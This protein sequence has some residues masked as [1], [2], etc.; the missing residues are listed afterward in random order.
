MPLSSMRNG[1]SFVPWVDAAVLHDPQPAGGDLLGHPVVEEDDA[2][3]DVLLQALARE[4]SLA[5]LAGD[6]PPSARGP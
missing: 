1:Y 4:R 3:G 6:A 5:P 2:V